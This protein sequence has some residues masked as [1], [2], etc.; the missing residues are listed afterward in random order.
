MTEGNIWK[1]ILAFSIPLVLGNLLQEMYNT[2]DSIIVGNYVGSSALAAVSAGTTLINLFIAFSQGTAVGAGVVVS[3]YL[4]AENKKKIQ[5][6]VHT[7]LAI[8]I[9]IGL[10]LSLIGV[11]FG[12]QILAWMKT[13]KEVFEEAT[14][15]FRLYSVGLIFNVVYNMAAGILNAAG[16]VN[17]SLW[18]LGIASVTNILLDL[19]LIGELGMGIE[20]V[21]IATDISQAIACILALRFLIRSQE[22]YQIKLRKIRIQKSM[23]KYMIRIGLPA[24]IQNM[25][26]SFSNVIIQSSVN[27][28]GADVMAGFGVYLKIDGFNIMPI[29]SFAMAG[30]TF[31]GQNYGAGKRKRIRDGMWVTLCIGAIYSAVT[32]ILLLMFSRELMG[33]FTDKQ[34]VIE[35]GV[36][37]TYYFCPFYVC[38]SILHI[39][40]GIVRGTG[41]TIQPMFIL[42]GSMCVFR[43][44]WVQFITPNFFHSIQ[45]VYIVYPISWI[46]GMSLMALYTWRA[47]I[48]K[49]IKKCE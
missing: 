23:A 44:V 1:Q 7:S 22:N 15:Y 35:Y 47:N 8:S 32:G 3:Q 28:F 43:A 42:L 9:I 16:K 11:L 20:G 24:G 33:L 12:H 26:V 13:P 6:S 38:L 45:G 30:T 21:A 46:L 10:C 31:T 37:A 14:I 34:E 49:E 4:G 18:Y 36:L 19:F 48:A 27:G 29:R 2:V 5:L 40:A 41:R 17:T 25:V 39:L